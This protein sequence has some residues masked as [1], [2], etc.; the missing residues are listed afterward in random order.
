[1]TTQAPNRGLKDH[2]IAQLTNAIRDRLE[3]HSP[4][5]ES[6]RILISTTIVTWLT[7]HGLKIDP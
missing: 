2:E 6:L 7:E 1:M 3:S 4:Q 5:S